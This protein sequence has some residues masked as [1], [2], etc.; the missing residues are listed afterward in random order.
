MNR[1]SALLAG[2]TLF[3]ATAVPASADVLFSQ[4][5]TNTTNWLSQTA[6]GSSGYNQVYDNFIIGAGGTVTTVDWT[7]LMFPSTGVVNDFTISFYN[8]SGSDTPGTLI[9]SLNIAGDA[10][11]TEVGTH[12][13][14]TIFD[15][16]ASV[17]FTAAPGTQY[18]ISILAD[19]P[20]TLWGWSSST[21]LDSNM[22]QA[23]NDSVLEPVATD[24]AFTL[25]NSSPVPEPS[26]L[27]LVGSG[28]LALAGFA[29]RRF[30]R[31]RFA[32]R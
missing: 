5:P 21:G 13:S 6:S 1:V 30:A 27:T 17:P 22:F 3:V 4:T 20:D 19:A 2:L 23:G 26:S 16:S 15:Y 8:D 28:V 31:R 18:W 32:R 9:S 24:V 29:R 10:N 7:G 14:F 25:L 11:Q 12:G